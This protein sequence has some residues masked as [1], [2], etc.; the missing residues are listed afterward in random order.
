MSLTTDIYNAFAPL[1]TTFAAGLSP[2]LPV[3]YPNLNFDPPSEGMWLDFRTFWNGNE[4]Y[5]MSDSGPSIE[6]GFFRIIVN[7][8]AGSGQS[9]AQA[10]AELIATA[11]P[12]GTTFNVARTD[13]APEI[14][15]PIQDDPWLMIPVTIYWRATR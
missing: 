15:G 1:V 13:R 11:F 9:A 3:A 8:P 6:R 12:K 14:T 7:A 4:N 2:A 5:G 10:V